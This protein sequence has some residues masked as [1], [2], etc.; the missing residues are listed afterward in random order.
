MTLGLA[1]SLVVLA[2][3]GPE[4]GGPSKPIPVPL[5]DVRSGTRS[6]PVYR[7]DPGVSARVDLAPR[8]IQLIWFLEEIER[9]HKIVLLAEHSLRMK[10]FYLFTPQ[11][12][13]GELLSDLMGQLGQVFGAQWYRVSDRYVLARDI[14]RVPESALTQNECSELAS[15]AVNAI[16]HQ[17]SSEQWQRLDA[18]E[19][20]GYDDLS[21]EQ[22]Q[23]ATDFAAAS[24]PRQL[25]PEAMQIVKPENFRLTIMGQPTRELFFR[26]EHFDGKHVWPAGGIHLEL[27]RV[28]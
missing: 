5:R 25:T 11:G 10:T 18:R 1:V 4:A 2:L 26:F 13:G 7:N 21:P 23:L 24:R 19:T 27:S 6:R 8:S 16:T 15:A 14:R 28:R 9:A 3:Q 20:L 12:G 17:L 22:R